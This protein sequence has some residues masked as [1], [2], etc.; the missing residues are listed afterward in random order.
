MGKPQIASGTDIYTVSK[1]QT[2]K[3]V[4]TTHIYADLVSAKKQETEFN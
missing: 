4:T 3:N 2:P 1:M